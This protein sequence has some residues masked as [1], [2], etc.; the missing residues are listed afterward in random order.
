MK[1]VLDKALEDHK[2][3]IDPKADFSS[4]EMSWLYKHPTKRINR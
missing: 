2:L 4:P 3:Q 1:D